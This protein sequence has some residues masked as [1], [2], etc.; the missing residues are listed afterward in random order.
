TGRECH[1]GHRAG[2]DALGRAGPACG[3]GK[4]ARR[5]LRRSSCHPDHPRAGARRRAHQRLRGSGSMQDRPSVAASPTMPDPAQPEGYDEVEASKAPLIDHLIEL[6]QR[7][8][9]ALAG[10][11][12]GFAICF[13]F[14]TQIYDVLVWP[15]VWAQGGKVVMQ[16]T[17]PH[18]FLFTKLK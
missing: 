8:I 13:V 18:E 5:A 10:V 7:L 14:A 2:H 16:Y 4:R 17:A 1:P 9:Y 12:V 15:Y 3:G 6:R 11:A